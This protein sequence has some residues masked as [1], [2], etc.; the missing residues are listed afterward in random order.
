MRAVFM[1]HVLGM[2]MLLAAHGCSSLQNYTHK[3][4]P[5]RMSIDR[6]DFQ[7][8][9]A[10]FPEK[11]ARGKD[12]VLVRLERGMIL[13]DGGKF[14]LSS[15][16]FEQADRKMGEFEEKAMISAGRTA[17]QA[18]TLLINEQVMPYEG[19]DFE[20]ILLHA[21][22]AVN[23]LMRG[24]LEGARVEI[25]KSY[26]KQEELSEKHAKDLEKAE[27]EAGSQDWERSFQ[28]ADYRGYERLKQ[29]A[30]SVYSVYHNAFA[31][32]ISALVYELTGEPD[33]AYIDLKKAIIASPQSRSIQKDLIRLSRKLN[34][35]EDTRQ[36]EERFGI[37]GNIPKKSIDVF[38]IF[39]TGLG[40]YKEAISFPIPIHEGLVFASLPVYSFTPSAP[41]S[42]TIVSDGM[43]VETSVVFDTDA[44]AARNLL[45]DFP[46]IF[47]KQIARS[48]L[49]AQATSQLAHEHGDWG[50]IIGTL[51]SGIT[52]RADLRTWSSLPKE[53]QV[54][55]AFL[56]QSTKEILI[57][58]LPAGFYTAVPV[59]SGASHLIV[60]CRATDIGLNIYTKSF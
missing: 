38:V 48:Y 36:W 17:Y 8:A 27:K 52:E 18:G 60:L 47:V 30:A 16:E 45:D 11:S 55:R 33:E 19:E 31:S 41:S 13:Q 58:A 43:S 57:R 26:Q 23:Y 35:P 51:F 53:I 20:K 2:S 29:K 28:Q 6:G 5:A 50:A 12:E 7:G 46:I 40:P 1:L 34:N 24:D 9:L 10:T 32:Y 49:K 14:A 25:R 59:P 3:T 54:G 44:T 22:D 56:P 15:S 39:S 4:A 42:G 37:V 21:L